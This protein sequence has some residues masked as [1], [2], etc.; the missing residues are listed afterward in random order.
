VLILCNVTISTARN[1]NSLCEY[2]ITRANTVWLAL[3]HSLAD[4]NNSEL[5]PPKLNKSSAFT[6]D[7]LDDALACHLALVHRTIVCAA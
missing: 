3:V 2:Y 1:R 6:Y 5:T 7:W 4:V